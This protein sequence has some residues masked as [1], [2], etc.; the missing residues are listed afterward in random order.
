M[1][2]KFMPYQ[3]VSSVSG[4]KITVTTVKSFIRSFCWIDSCA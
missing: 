3:P 1:P 2:E 4:R